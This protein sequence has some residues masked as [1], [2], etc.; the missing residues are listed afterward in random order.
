MTLEGWGLGLS[1]FG[2]GAHSYQQ[3]RVISARIFIG[4]NRVH[5]NRRLL[6]TLKGNALILATSRDRDDFN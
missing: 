6:L 2:I 3:S 1:D 5:H 4:S